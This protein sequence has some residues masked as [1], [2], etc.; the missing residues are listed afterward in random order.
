M[1]RAPGLDLLRAVAIL[2]VMYY[3]GAVLGLLPG[4]DPVA[5]PGWVFAWL[6]SARAPCA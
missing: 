5:A 6:N 1:N 3:H 4:S 2:W